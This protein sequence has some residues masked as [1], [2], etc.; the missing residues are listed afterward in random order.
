MALMAALSIGLSGQGTGTF[1]A[2]WTFK[3]SALT[4]MQQVGNAT[5][6]AENGEII[7]TP[8]SSRR[9][10]AAARQGLSGRAGRR[11]V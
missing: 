11:V 10:L 7:G 5:W 6:R 1:V 2:D 8:T 9:R 4:G 3:G